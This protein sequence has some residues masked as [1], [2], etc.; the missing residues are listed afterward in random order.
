MTKDMD[1]LA[2]WF[3]NVLN[4]ITKS[5]E[6]LLILI[7]RIFDTSQVN[8]F[9]SDKEKFGR[10]NLYQTFVLYEYDHFLIYIVRYVE[11]LV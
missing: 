7:I 8:A 9:K 4:A 2:K 1:V 10:I 11:E 5:E 6:K 3:F